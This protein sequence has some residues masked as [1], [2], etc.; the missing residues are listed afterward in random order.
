MPLWLSRL[1]TLVLF[2]AAMALVWWALK[3]WGEPTLDR[4]YDGIGGPAAWM[5]LIALGLFCAYVA[6]WPCNPGG[7]RRP[8]LPPRR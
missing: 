6:Y 4:F 7:S 3:A 1:L 2:A 8:L 5:I